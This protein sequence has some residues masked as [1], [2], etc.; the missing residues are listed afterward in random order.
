MIIINSPLFN[1]K[2][3]N[4]LMA[5]FNDGLVLKAELVLALL[6][7]I[8]MLVFVLD[9]TITVNNMDVFNGSFEKK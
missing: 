7:Q 2:L 4:L 1:G 6:V 3:I 9:Y 5:S 8:K